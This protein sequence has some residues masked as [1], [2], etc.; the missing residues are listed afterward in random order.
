MYSGVT[1]THLRKRTEKVSHVNTPKLLLKQTTYG[2]V[3]L[4]ASRAIDIGTCLFCYTYLS[5][6]KFLECY[7]L[8]R[9]C[10]L[11]WQA[12]MKIEYYHKHIEL[13]VYAINCLHNGTN[14]KYRPPMTFLS[15]YW[16]DHLSHWNR[17]G[18]TW[19]LWT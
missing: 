2:K 10:V 8:L 9:V 19:Y 18:M 16:I 14:L 13:Y 15:C 4:Y 17:W 3:D 7:R 6:S 5:N 11:G 12:S 1:S